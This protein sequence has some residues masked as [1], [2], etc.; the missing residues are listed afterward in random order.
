MRD[1]EEREGE[2]R[3]RQRREEGRER[4]REREKRGRERREKRDSKI[5]TRKT[6][7]EISCF[8]ERFF[9]DKIALEHLTK[10]IKIQFI[11]QSL[12]I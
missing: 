6:I 5:L 8:H 11:K 2:E 9:H 3:E 10:S 7:L 1:R 4:E 12:E